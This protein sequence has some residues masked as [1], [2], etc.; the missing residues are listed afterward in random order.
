MSDLRH[1]LHACNVRAELSW[2]GGSHRWAF[3]GD[4]AADTVA[5]VGTLS[6]LVPDAPGPLALSLHLTGPAKASATYD[7]KIAPDP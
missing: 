1:P 3:T 7:A 2:P 6:F 5:R 4:I